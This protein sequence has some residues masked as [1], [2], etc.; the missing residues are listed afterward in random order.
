MVIISGNLFYLQHNNDL[1][2]VL[3]E[4]ILMSKHNISFQDK[5]ENCPKYLF[6]CAI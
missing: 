6:S 1:L 3:D 2:S 5:K 4:A